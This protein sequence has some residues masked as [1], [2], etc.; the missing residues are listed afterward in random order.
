M[1]EPPRDE[2]KPVTIYDVQPDPKAKVVVRDLPRLTRAALSIAWR[3][4]RGEFVASTVLQLIGGL[5]IG[6]L[7]LLGQRGLDALLDAIQEGESLRAVLPWV[8]AIGAVVAVQSFV[9]SVQRGATARSSA[10]SCRRH[11]EQRVLDVTAS[12]DLLAFETP[13]FH[14]RVQRMRMSGPQPLNLVFG[15]SGLVRAAFGIVGVVVALLTIEPL[16]VPLVCLV[17]LPAWLVASRRGESYYRFFW[18]MTPRDR[19]R[20]YLASVLTDRDSAK[21]VRAFGL[22]A[23]PPPSVRRAVRRADSASCA[24]ARRQLRNSLV[25]NLGIAVVLVATLLLE[26]GPPWAAAS[27]SRPPASRWPA[28]P[29]SASG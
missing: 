5:G 12:V 4:G 3:A 18:R 14:N 7:L 1:A 24:L 19:E 23:L 27:R 2:T 17:F 15:L 10:S 8:L 6:A 9:S 21:E 16:L 20:T 28:S 11:V 13:S 26:R 25:A 22:R 29:S